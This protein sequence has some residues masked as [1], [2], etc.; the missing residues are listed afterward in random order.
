[1]CCCLSVRL[2]GSS[3]LLQIYS[4]QGKNWRTVCSL[5][6]TEQQGRAS[7]QQIGYSR[8]HAPVFHWTLKPCSSIIW[9]VKDSRVWM[10]L[11]CFPSQG[12]VF[13]IRPTDDQLW[14]WIPKSEVWLQVWCVHTAAAC[15]QVSE[16][17]SLSMIISVNPILP[18]MFLFFFPPSAVIPVLTTVWWLCAV[19]VCYY[20]TS[21][22]QRTAMQ[23]QVVFFIRERE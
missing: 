18:Q 15:P 21:S 22:K 19:L 3:F 8:W 2:Q 16:L 10:N 17:L 1:M 5:G 6:W 9:H 23:N 4:T 14:G 7:C 20:H 12:H 13:Q 11:L